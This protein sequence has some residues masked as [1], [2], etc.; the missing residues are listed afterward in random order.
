MDAFQ[1]ACLTLDILASP[2]E[3]QKLI[4]RRN[5]AG[6]KEGWNAAAPLLRLS[7]HDIEK[8]END[9]CALKAKNALVSGSSD[10]KADKE[11]G[12]L[13]LLHT[14]GRSSFLIKACR[15]KNVIND[16]FF[17]K[18]R[19]NSGGEKECSLFTTD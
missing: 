2:C 5:F 15:K 11:R 19:N 12:T 8:V 10:I 16:I 3:Q 6:S 1:E 7:I 9:R 17:A 14:Q 18:E 4:L 13:F